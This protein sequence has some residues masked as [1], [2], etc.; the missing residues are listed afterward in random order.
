MF[1]SGVAECFE[2]EHGCTETEWLRALP[3]AVRQHPLQLSAPGQAQVA[4][5]DGVLQ[6]R[7]TTLPPRQIALV[8]MPRLQV[9]FRFDGVPAPQRQAFMDYFDLYMLKGGG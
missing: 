2:R 8:R 7:W 9:Q 6:L 1:P 5:A 4:I 3:G